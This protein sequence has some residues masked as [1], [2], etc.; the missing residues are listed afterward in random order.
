MVPIGSPCPPVA[1]LPFGQLSRR[2]WRSSSRLMTVLESGGNCAGGGGGGGAGGFG[3]EPPSSSLPPQAASDNPRMASTSPRV[4]Y[5]RR[6]IACS[7]N[8]RTMFMRLLP[9]RSILS[10]WGNPSELNAR[11]GPRT[12][13]WRVLQRPSPFRSTSPAYGRICR[14]E[15]QRAA[16][17]TGWEP[18]SW[19]AFYAHR[20][21]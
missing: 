16:V 8:P 14:K 17:C 19:V 5:E 3:V 21:A 1:E 2:I 15:L 11:G 4:R 10:V 12:A 20:Y 6:K 7:C 18:S 9:V 13:Q